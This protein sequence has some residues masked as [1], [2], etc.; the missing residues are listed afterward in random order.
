MT[1]V[2]GS[3]TLQQQVYAFNQIINVAFGITEFQTLPQLQQFVNT[4]LTQTM[5]DPNFPTYMG[6]DWQMLWGPV[7]FSNNPGT[8]STVADN[9]MALFYSP[10]QKAYVVAIAGTNLDSAYGWLMEDF[11][12]TDTTLWSTVMGSS[13]KIPSSY[14]NAAISNG[15]LN[16]L[17][18]LIGMQAGSTSMISAL[19][20]SLNGLPAGSQV[21]V[22][23]SGHS[24]GG[25]LC[26][27]MALY[28]HDLQQLSNNWNAKGYVTKITATPTAGPTPGEVNFAA[29]Y[30]YQCSQNVKGQAS[31]GYTSVYNTLDIVPH[32][33]QKDE[34]A[35]IP[36]LY[37]GNIPAENSIGA[38]TV[39]AFVR[40]CNTYKTEF[41]KKI[42]QNTYTQVSA[43]PAVRTAV[44]GTFNKTV[45][46]DVTS[47]TSGISFILPLTLIQY[48]DNFKNLL[49]FLAQ[50]GYQ[51]TTAYSGDPTTQTQG[52]LN[53]VQVWG[54]MGQ[55][56]QKNLPSGS[57]DEQLHTAALARV[58]G[59]DLGSIDTSGLEASAAS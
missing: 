7:V 38:I 51:H 23:V 56:K 12:V 13:F 35:Q 47:K 2:A 4:V 30:S 52:I 18:A 36:G 29:Y 54:I 39:G 27:V 9:V 33:W 21:Q 49:R 1:Y 45:D 44:T 8:N 48:A 17:N 40:A 41:G 5:Q 43:S 14:T 37:S 3:Y 19:T 46:S 10:N 32:S 15:S 55:Y 50:A 42:P 25:A 20:T 24:L 53:V 57:T 58:S 26:P 11:D 6:N 22:C 59:F 28:L 16:G 34:L 31:L